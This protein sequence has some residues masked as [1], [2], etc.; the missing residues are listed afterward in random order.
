MRTRPGLA[1]IGAYSHIVSGEQQY[2]VTPKLKA[3][4]DLFITGS[5]EVLTSDYILKVAARSCSIDV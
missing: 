4:G 1:D 5:L 2:R 3:F